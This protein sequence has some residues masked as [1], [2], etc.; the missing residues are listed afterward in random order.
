[1]TVPRD[2]R[3]LVFAFA[4][5]RLFRGAGKPQAWYMRHDLPYEPWCWS[6]GPGARLGQCI[7]EN[8]GTPYSLHE[9]PQQTSA[10]TKLGAPPLAEWDETETTYS[11][12]PIFA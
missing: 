11:P 12:L 10:Y 1:M 8:D 6:P 3:R 9:V 7:Y 2:L 5:W 4:G